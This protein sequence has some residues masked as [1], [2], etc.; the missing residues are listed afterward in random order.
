MQIYCAEF[1]YIRKDLSKDKDVKGRVCNPI[2]CQSYWN[3]LRN[4]RRKFVGI[5]LHENNATSS[6]F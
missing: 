3:G 1:M 6:Q 2:Y 4:Y 5:I